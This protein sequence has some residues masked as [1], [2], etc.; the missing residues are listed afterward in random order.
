MSLAR[1][2]GGLYLEVLHIYRE[3]WLRIFLLALAIFIPVGL[4]E[5]GAEAA[6]ESLNP[7]HEVQAIAI[8]STV[9]IVTATSMLGA[10]FLAGVIGISIADSRNGHL[11]SLRHIAG[12]I[13]YLRL[14]LL[15]LV[16]AVLIL[17]GLILLIVPGVL[18]FVLFG[19]A[20]PVVEIE[21]RR[22]WSALR[23]SAA[24]VRTDF[25]LAFWALLP[26]AMLTNSLSTGVSEAAAGLFG[27]S[28]VAEQM[29][30]AVSEAVFSPLLAIAAVL[31]TLQLIDR[32]GAT[33]EPQ[34]AS[35]AAA[36]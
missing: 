23:R 24:L 3:W 22:L 4:L 36:A 14:I 10:V 13:R 21:H 30:S 2:V 18:L 6:L 20:G 32:H 33:E 25:W 19:L 31:L 8:L 12:R 15:D 1:R 11:P 9:G 17:L 34:P 7:D 27:Q 35:P 16:F 29:S 28:V 26:P 5:A